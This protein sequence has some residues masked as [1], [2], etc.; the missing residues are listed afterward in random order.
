MIR[1]L[2][3]D[4]PAEH[5]ILL[6]MGSCDIFKLIPYNILRVNGDIRRNIRLADFILAISKYSDNTRMNKR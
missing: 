4:T 1:S 3:R 2:C 6:T 5:L